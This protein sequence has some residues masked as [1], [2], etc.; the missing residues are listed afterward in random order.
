MLAFNHCLIFHSWQHVTSV[1]LHASPMFLTFGLRWYALPKD[2]FIVCS[3]YTQIGECNVGAGRLLWQS[4]SGFYLWWIV[5]YYIFVMVLMS[6]YLQ[7]RGFV[8][9]FNR[10]NSSLNPVYRFL[11]LPQ[12]HR[13]SRGGKQAEAAE[14]KTVNFIKKSVYV[15]R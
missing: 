12:S 9:L 10:V 1:F 4:I 2:G 3:N 7:K 14:S 5:L 13:Q 11:G 8:T 6:D 15:I